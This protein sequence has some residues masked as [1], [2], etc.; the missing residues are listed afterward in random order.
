[1]SWLRGMCKRKNISASTKAESLFLSDWNQDPGRGPHDFPSEAG[2]DL[3]VESKV[4]DA[5]MLFRKD[6]T[7]ILRVVHS[8]WSGGFPM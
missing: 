7:H 8:Q 6:V 4:R 2:G 1:M 5:W 3:E